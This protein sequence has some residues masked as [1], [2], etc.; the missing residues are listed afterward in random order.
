M[1]GSNKGTYLDI[2]VGIVKYL[3]TLFMMCA[4]F[5]FGLISTHMMTGAIIS[6]NLQNI[7]FFKYNI[8][9]KIIKYYYLKNL[10]I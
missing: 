3:S 5:P 2:R 10:I 6:A 7:G 1:A 8:F 4:G 9:N